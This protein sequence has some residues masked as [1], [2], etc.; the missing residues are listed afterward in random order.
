MPCRR[1]IIAVKYDGSSDMGMLI[2]VI[3]REGTPRQK[4]RASQARRSKVARERGLTLWHERED[5]VIAAAYRAAPQA[6]I[7][8]KTQ[9]GPCIPLKFAPQA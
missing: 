4:P 7:A 5:L 2:R 6:E 9:P 3:F 1:F 8:R